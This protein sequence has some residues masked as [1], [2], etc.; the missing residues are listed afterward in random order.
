MYSFRTWEKRT[1]FFDQRKLILEHFTMRIIDE[2]DDCEGV[3]GD[4]MS[5][6]FDD[7]VSPHP[8]LNPPI[9]PLYHPP[10][11]PSPPTTVLAC[12]K[13]LQGGQDVR[14]AVCPPGVATCIPDAE[15][16]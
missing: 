12:A 6:E 10:P 16:Q 9:H 4:D 5:E 14:E 1:E 15:V 8:K 2:D 7:E 3:G 11:P 13:A